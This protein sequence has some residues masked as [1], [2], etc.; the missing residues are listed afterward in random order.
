MG[1]K[2][3]VI[4][5]GVSQKP[6]TNALKAGVDILIATPGRLIDL[7]NQKYINLH[8]VKILYLMRQIVCLTWV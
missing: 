2:N 1:L 3:I 8:N 4:F 7:I 5:G 6:Q